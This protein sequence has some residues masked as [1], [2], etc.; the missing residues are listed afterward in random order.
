MTA[1]LSFAVI[2]L[3]VLL[4]GL[5][6]AAEFAII[7]VRPSRIEQL[8]EG[9]NRAARWV[10]GVL[11]NP[12]YTDRYIATAQL[13]ITL[14]SL[15][16][17]MIGE[18]AIAHLIEDPLH[19]WFG[20]GQ[21]AIH[22]ISFFFALGVITYLHVVVGEMV[23]KSISLQTAERAA[24]LLATPMDVSERLF[25]IPVKFLNAIGLLLLRLLGIPAADENRRL[26][27]PEELELIVSESYESGLLT[28][29]EQQ[30]VANIFDF[31]ERRVGQ[32]MTPRPMMTTVPATISEEKLQEVFITSAYSRLPVYEG[33][34]DRVIGILHLKDLAR[35][36]LSG[37]PFDLHKLLRKAP[38]VPETAPV[39]R[40]LS[41]FKKLHLHM[42][43]VID[44]HGSTVGL[45]TLEDLIEEIVGEVR[46]EFDVDEEEPITVV[47]PGH[48]RVQGTVLI[49]DLEE[50]VTFG[51]HEHDVQTIGGLALAALSRPPRVGDEMAFGDVRL[52]VEA[53]DGLAITR[54]S[55]FHPAR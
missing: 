2:L 31:G 45:V 27:S 6:V 16:L 4:N 20:L 7:G 21:T 8:A 1:L 39:E 10:R 17:G 33:T 53:V 40:L 18:P 49:E 29:R 11:D 52:R 51:D 28:R 25:A 44:E 12:R 38:V 36:Q 55:V 19:D 50:Y 42:A 34:I 43:M 26:Y 24:L 22:T 37:E 35:Q 54:L 23:P 3:L 46:D 41:S 14:A 9:G 5:Y 13:G 32:V 47:E 48:L 30:L 15:G